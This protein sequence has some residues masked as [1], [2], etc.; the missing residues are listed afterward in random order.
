[1]SPETHGSGNHNNNNNNDY[2]QN[3]VNNT[4]ENVPQKS[5]KNTIFKEEFLFHN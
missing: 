5:L 3:N 1:V 4:R 2:K